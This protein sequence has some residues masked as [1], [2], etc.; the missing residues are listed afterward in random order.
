MEDHE[1][2]VVI[3]DT[4]NNVLKVENVPARSARVTIYVQAG[5]PTQR[6]GDGADAVDSENKL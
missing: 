1:I 3:R 6:T 2:E 4:N 5:N